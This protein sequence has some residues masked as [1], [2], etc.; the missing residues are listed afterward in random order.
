M[1]IHTVSAHLFATMLCAAAVWLIPGRAAGQIYV[2]QDDYTQNSFAV[3]ELSSSGGGSWAAG[4][5]HGT[6]AVGGDTLYNGNLYVS[7]FNSTGAYVAEYNATTGGVENSSLINQGGDGMAA[8]NGNLYIAT[9]NGVMEYNATTGAPVNSGTLVSG[10]S[11]PYGLAISSGNL[12]VSDYAAGTISEY[13][14][15]SGTMERASVLSTPLNSPEGITISGSNLYALSFTSEGP[16]VAQIGEYTLSGS[17]VNATLVTNLTNIPHFLATSG[18]NLYVT[19]YGG[20][21]GGS[22]GVYNATSGTTVTPDLTYINSPQGIAVA[23]TAPTPVTPTSQTTSVSAGANYST[24]PSAASTGGYGSTAA[25]IGGTASSSVNVTLAFNGNG[26]FANIGSDVVTVSGMPNK[27][28]GP[29]GSTL[30]DMFVLK[31]SVNIGAYSLLNNEGANDWG[32]LWLNPSTGKWVNA[33]LGN[34]DGGAG[35]AFLGDVAYDPSSDFNLG[36]YGLYYDASDPQ[37][38]YMWV[39]LDHNST[40]VVGDPDN[41]PFLEAVPEPSTWAI[42]A[43]GGAGLVLARRRVKLPQ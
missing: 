13:D 1:K 33:I 28:T 36:W 21:G 30:T 17:T 22:I 14:A 5:P 42:L 23:A 6:E 29:G 24:V 40:F 19:N 12:Y 25:I 31:I 7:Y 16:P 20:V 32:M 39:V 43:M 34:S 26:N 41:A 11:Y 27:G 4:L 35:G 10:L 38:S 8:Y 9:G 15:T 18:S 37:D 2:T 3:F